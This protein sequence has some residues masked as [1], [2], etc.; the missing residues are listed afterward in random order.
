MRAFELLQFPAVTPDGPSRHRSQFEMC[1]SNCMES[2]AISYQRSSGSPTERDGHAGY[3]L[4]GVQLEERDLVAYHGEDYA[5]YKKR[6][7]MIVP[8]AGGRRG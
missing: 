1:S 4:L 5:Q 3:I 6:V 7:P 8:G 2:S